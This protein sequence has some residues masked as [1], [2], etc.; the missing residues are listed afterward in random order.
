MGTV[1]GHGDSP[2]AEGLSP[3]PGTVPAIREPLEPDEP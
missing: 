2:Q 1:P 3:E